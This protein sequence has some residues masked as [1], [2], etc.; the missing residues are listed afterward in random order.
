[1]HLPR[2]LRAVLRRS[3]GIS[4]CLPFYRCWNFYRFLRSSVGC[5]RGRRG[6][7]RGEHGRKREQKP[8]DRRSLSRGMLSSHSQPGLDARLANEVRLGI[9]RRTL[10]GPHLSVPYPSCSPETAHY[11][12]SR[13]Q[14]RL[15]RL[16][17]LR[18]PR[19]LLSLS[20]TSRT[21]SASDSSP[22]LLIPSCDR[23][24]GGS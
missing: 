22:P 18:R 23:S 7:M 4:P 20:A 14:E 6:S 3:T 24:R 9:D 17:R 15:R 2:Y 5:E 16:R 19:R 11:S 1:M 8:V 12:S 21:P 13:L 10:T